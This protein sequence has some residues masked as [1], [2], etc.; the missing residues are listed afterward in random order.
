MPTVRVRALPAQFPFESQNPDPSSTNAY[1]D[2]WRQQV[3]TSWRENPRV[4]QAAGNMSVEC[5]DL[6]DKV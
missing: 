1:N 5:R 4:R 2:V 3:C 6:L